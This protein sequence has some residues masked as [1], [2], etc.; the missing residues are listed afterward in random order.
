MNKKWTI[1]ILCVVASC[2]ALAKV[3]NREIAKC[4]T[5]KGDLQRLECYDGIARKNGL[6]REQEQP[7]ST[8]GNGKWNVRSTIN[9]VDDSK[10]VTLS[11]FSDSGQGKWGDRVY[12]IIRCKSD[13]TDLYINW[14]DYLGSEAHVLTRIG[15]A[16]AST[17]YWLLSTDK[18]ATFKNKPIS[19]IKKMMESN[20]MVAQVTPY[21]ENPVTAVFDTTGLKSAIAPLRATCHW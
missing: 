16:K 8:T 10:T 15:S 2:N 20:K 13:T 6:M 4:A 18:K 19:F 11:L 9:P 17:A 7:L 14:N 1:P 3:D 12:L 21:N 5:I